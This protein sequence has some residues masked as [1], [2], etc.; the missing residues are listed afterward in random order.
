MHCFVTMKETVSP[1]VRS[2]RQMKYKKNF[3]LT[4]TRSYNVSHKKNVKKKQTRTGNLMV[5]ALLKKPM[6]AYCVAPLCKGLAHVAHSYNI[7]KLSTQ[8]TLIRSML[9][10][11]VSKSK[12]V[13]L[14]LIYSLTCSNMLNGGRLLSNNLPTV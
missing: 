7:I 12:E 6:I 3:R 1:M 2:V 13:D 8:V 5:V 10:H 11:C 14:S 4:L 9:V